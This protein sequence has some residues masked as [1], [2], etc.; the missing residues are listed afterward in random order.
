MEEE[1]NR[2]CR[3]CEQTKPIEEFVLMRSKRQPPYRQLQCRACDNKRQR[4][5]YA[6]NGAA[7]RGSS[8]RQYAANPGKFHRLPAEKYWAMWESQGGVCSICEMPESKISWRTGEV[9]RLTIDHDHSCCP[10]TRSC[11]KCVRGLLCDKCNMGIGRF[12]D[13]LTLLRKAVGYL[14]KWYNK[15]TDQTVRT[16]T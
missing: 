14:E 12:A 6:R 13:D 16:K 7:S 10:G 8:A 11:G 4:V 1:T 15:S 5:A 2:K 9:Q 3:D